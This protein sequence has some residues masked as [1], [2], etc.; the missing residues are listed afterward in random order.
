MT[1][2]G[3]I[4]VYSCKIIRLGVSVSIF[5]FELLSSSFVM[6][7]ALVLQKY[8][9]FI[10]LFRT[11]GSH[12]RCSVIQVLVKEHLVLLIILSKIPTTYAQ[13]RH[14]IEIRFKQ[15]HTLNKEKQILRDLKQS[16]MLHPGI[17]PEWQED[18]A[19]S[20]VVSV[21]GIIKHWL[22]L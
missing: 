20:D 10:L 9:I 1:V 18:H 14:E 15:L 4:K 13:Q 5:Y 6:A 16:Y 21:P 2:V 12:A 17:R 3:P 11:V 8:F 19:A 22:T 7:L